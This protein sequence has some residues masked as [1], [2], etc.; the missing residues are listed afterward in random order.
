MGRKN[1]IKGE[2][3]VYRHIAPNGK[4]YIGVT[5]QD[6]K[7]RWLCGH[8]YDR[9]D[10]FRKAI[11]KYGWDNFRHDVLMSGLVKEKAA[12]IERFYIACFDSANPEK[13]FNLDTGGFIA[14]KHSAQT[15]RK[16]SETRIA[17]GYRSPT[18]GKHLS[19]E[20]KKKISEANKGNHNHT[21]WTDEQKEKLRQS[22]R[23]ENN[24]NYGK[25]MSD[26]CRQALLTKN[27]KPVEQV[28]DGFVIATFSNAVEAMRAT[29][30][31][32]TNICRVCNGRRGTAG[33]FE[34][35]FA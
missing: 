35:R 2:Y 9:N 22:K 14:G 5:S 16:I 1:S 13:G 28:K 10:Y 6:P 19:A 24:P 3:S 30:V 27:S 31:N 11:K 8:G 29:G 33:G 34:W 18:E 25:P 21:V 12:K 7:K 32:S 15:R 17:R 20:T 26:K 23:G 4:V